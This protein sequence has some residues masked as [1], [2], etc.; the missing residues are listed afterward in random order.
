LAGGHLLANRGTPYEEGM[1]NTGKLSSKTLLITG[2]MTGIGLATAKL[3]AAE[4]ARVVV[5]GMNPATLEA[6]R[7]ELPPDATVVASDA[8][9]AVDLAALAADLA[10]RGTVLDG[11]FL[12]AG[13]AKFAPLAEL[14]EAVLDEVLRV[15]VKGPALAIKH[16]APLVRNGGAIVFNTSIN[17][18]LGMAG[19]GM[20]AASKAAARS[21]VRVA[22]VELAPRNV[23]VN[24]VSPGP[25]ETP[26]YGKLGMP[27][28]TVKDF[29]TQLV[30]QIA[31]GRF[32]RA[33]EVARAVRFL[34][35]DDASFMTGDELVIDGGMLQQ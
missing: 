24:A 33:D 27:V 34:L 20:Y 18:Q 35:S 14:D 7:R 26:L 16:L 4:G 23:R 21:L 32:G 2:G 25:I 5:T 6:A 17:N 15:N 13:I 31:L 10:A 1:T 22:A 9:S 28:E 19:S 3:L 29:A 30:Q 11:L 8:G 12:N